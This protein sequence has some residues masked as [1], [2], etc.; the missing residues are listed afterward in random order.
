MRHH[1]TTIV[2]ALAM[3]TILLAA[4]GP[5]LVTRQSAAETL[6][7]GSRIAVLPFDNLS[8]R[9]KVGVKITD[10]FQTLLTGNERYAVIEYGNTLDVMRRLRVRSS[11][12]ITETQ[13][14][15]LAL[16]LGINFIVTGTVLEFTEIDNNYLGKVPQVSFNTKLI[17]CASHKT[18]WVG[19]SNGSGDNSELLF[20]IGAV[21]SADRLARS[22]A[23]DAVGKIN[24]LFRSR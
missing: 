15:S 13:I 22:M 11:A 8:G 3:T 10:Y 18:I 5:S 17:D 14:D 24:A 7:R 12:M 16:A 20:G 1:S 6:P 19:V 2:L 4:C 9:E 21:R 23:S